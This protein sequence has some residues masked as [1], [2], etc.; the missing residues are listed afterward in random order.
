MRRF[1]QFSEFN[2]RFCGL[3]VA[4][5]WAVMMFAPTTGA[6]QSS[7]GQQAPPS[8]GEAARRARAEKQAAPTAKKVWTNDNIPTNPF[9]I[10]VVGPPL[11]VEEKPDADEQVKTDKKPAASA[12]KPKTL[13]EM[14]AELAKAQEKLALHEKELDL[15]KRDAA[16]QQQ[17][18]YAD[19]RANQDDA[20]QAQLAEVQ[21][22]L[23]TMQQDLEKERASVAE[24]QARVEKMKTAPVAPGEGPGVA[25]GNF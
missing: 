6:R 22:H 11:P 4:A 13:T 24:L 19:P 21:K 12:E 5:A 23:E 17:A 20:G 8:L 10:S 16:L 25:D 14:E 7:Q 3:L 18:F 2:G 9:A 15:S 1:G